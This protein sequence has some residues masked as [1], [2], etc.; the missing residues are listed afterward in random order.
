MSGSVV[1]DQSTR[2]T[3]NK[4]NRD[5][6]EILVATLERNPRLEFLVVPSHC[7]ESETVVKVD[8]EILLLLKEIFRRMVYVCTRH[9]PTSTFSTSH[10][11]Q[12]APFP[13][14]R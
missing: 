2:T 7:M 8:G 3:V 1:A 4:K 11:L 10:I 13:I 9:S 5:A 14:R 6:E 12:A